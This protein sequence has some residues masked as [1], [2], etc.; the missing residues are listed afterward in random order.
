MAG[1]GKRGNF[2]QVVAD[3]EN[4]GG[5]RTEGAFGISHGGIGDDFPKQYDFGPN[6]AGSRWG[7]P[8]D[9]FGITGAPTL[10]LSPSAPPPVRELKGDKLKGGR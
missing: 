8:A 4:P 7:G 5:V 1:I 9:T 6:I 3:G 10:T 2:A